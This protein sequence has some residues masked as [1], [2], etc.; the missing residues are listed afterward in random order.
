MISR[1]LYSDLSTR[2]ETEYT[3]CGVCVLSIAEQ[4]HK[5]NI[6]S[7]NDYK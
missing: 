1:C 6:K 2:T 5:L 3:Q 7:K 4:S